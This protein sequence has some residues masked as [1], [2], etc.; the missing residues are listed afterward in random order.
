MPSDLIANQHWLLWLNFPHF[1]NQETNGCSDWSQLLWQ[2]PTHR[3]DGRHQ[4]L[5]QVMLVF[6]DVWSWSWGYWWWFWYCWEGCWARRRGRSSPTAWATS[7]PLLEILLPGFLFLL[8]PYHYVIMSYCIST[9]KWN[10]TGS[11]IK[12]EEFL[13]SD[14]ACTE[15]RTLILPVR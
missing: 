8:L 1:K 12:K 3:Q 7:Q 4:H 10:I 9:T 14:I 11:L 13:E 5:G 6:D 15:G 2:N